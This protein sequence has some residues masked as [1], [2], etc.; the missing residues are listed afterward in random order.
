MELL[1]QASEMFSRGA[2]HLL[3]L[4][5]YVHQALLKSGRDA[6]PLYSA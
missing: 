4:Q 1:E 6:R 2:N 5:W 3:D